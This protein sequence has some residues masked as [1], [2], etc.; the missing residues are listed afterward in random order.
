M[1]ICKCL[2]TFNAQE[3]MDFCFEWTHTASIAFQDR[4]FQRFNI[5][6]VKTFFFILTLNRQPLFH[7]YHP[8]FWT[9][10][11]KKG[12]HLHAPCQNLGSF[13]AITTDLAYSISL[14]SPNSSSNPKNI[15]CTFYNRHISSWDQ[16]YTPWQ[17]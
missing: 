1:I 14:H 15:S 9:T 3:S 13:N 17:M 7:I 12:S 5:L 6:Q 11:P 4:E 2:D 8:W 16:K 10:W